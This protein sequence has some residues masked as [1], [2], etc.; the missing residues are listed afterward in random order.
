MVFGPMSIGSKRM[1]CFGSRAIRGSLLWT[2]PEPAFSCRCVRLASAR[3]CERSVRRDPDQAGRV[4]ADPLHGLPEG[5]FP[6]LLPVGAEDKQAD[7]LR[8]GDL[9]GRLDGL[10]VVERELRR[11][12]AVVACSFGDGVEML[13]VHLLRVLTGDVPDI[14]SVLER[15]RVADVEL[16]ASLRCRV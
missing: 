5:A 6:E 12:H 1:S 4:L 3:S 13:A 8:L 15:D 7:A 10:R 9:E 14:V 11:R 2:E 16:R